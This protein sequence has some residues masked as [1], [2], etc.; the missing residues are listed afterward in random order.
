MHEMSLAMEIGRIAEVKLGDAASQLVSV[1]VDVGDDAGVEPSS[2]EF[3][4]EA[5]F[6]TPPFVGAKPQILRCAGD[7][8]RVAYLEIDDGCPE[9]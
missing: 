6:A 5:V 7:V 9:D 8:L 1:A 2:L 3:C 4:L